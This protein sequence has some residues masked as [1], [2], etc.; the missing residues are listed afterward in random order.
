MSSGAIV[1]AGS[2]KK[3]PGAA[4]KPWY[5]HTVGG[6]GCVVVAADVD[7]SKLLNC[8]FC[9]F[10]DSGCQ[11][12]KKFSKITQKGLQKISFGRGIVFFGK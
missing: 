6:A 11:V 12:A 10:S 2:R 8:V 3:T 1:G 5:S 9:S 7:D 4:Q